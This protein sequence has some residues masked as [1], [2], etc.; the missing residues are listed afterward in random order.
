MYNSDAITS[1]KKRLYH[2]ANIALIQNSCKNNKII[3]KVVR[4]QL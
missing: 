3:S 2:H 4:I 1:N